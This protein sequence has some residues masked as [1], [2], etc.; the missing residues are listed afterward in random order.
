MFRAD[1]GCAGIGGVDVYP[2]VGMLCEDRAEG[3]EGVDCACGRCA[4]SERDVVGFEAFGGELGE[5]AG[6][7]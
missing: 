7:V 1:Q 5:S 2:D 6:E 3:A 4:E